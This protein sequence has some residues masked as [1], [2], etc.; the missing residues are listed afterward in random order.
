MGMEGDRRVA[1]GNIMAVAVPSKWLPRT[2]R[3][4]HDCMVEVDREHKVESRRVCSGKVCPA[5]ASLWT[6]QALF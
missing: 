2:E 5:M 6:P 4:V 1:C 3:D